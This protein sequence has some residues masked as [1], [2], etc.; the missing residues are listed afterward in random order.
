MAETDLFES[1]QALFCSVAD[2]LGAKDVGKVLNIKTYPTYKQFLEVPKHKNI[3]KKAAKQTN[4]DVSQKRIEDFLLKSDSWYKSSVQIANKVITEIHKIDK[5]FNLARK[6]YESAGFSWLRGDKEV[7]G[8]IFELYKLA[9]ESASA[10]FKWGGSKRVGMDLGFTSRNMNKWNPADIFYA[11][12]TARTAIKKELEKVR[13]L[14]G[15]KFYS[16]DNGTLNGK[17]RP[18]DG[19]NVF[20]A[21]LVDNGDL[22]PLS[23]KKQPGT[24]TLRPVN[25]DESTK[26]KL[27][28]SVEFDGATNWQPFKRLASDIRD[29]WKKIEKG[30]K[31]ETRD[32]QLKFKSDV[33]PGTIKIRHD[34]SGSGRFV[35]EAIY[36]GAKAKAG[37]IA[38][39]RDFSIIWGAVDPGPANSFIRA[40]DKGDKEFDKRK[41]EIGKDKDYL[42]KQKGGGTNQYD[43][44]MAAASAELITNATIPFIKKFFSGKSVAQKTKQNLFVRLMF[45]AITSRSPRSSRF[46]IA[47]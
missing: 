20:I 1:A 37:S 36:T 6:G 19:L 27:L 3:I 32:I 25:F 39:A 15:G 12:Q 10:N 21:R 2:L 16:F 44:Y 41:A 38:T 11:N 23:L 47:K 17:V 26:D 14:G 9:N 42:R 29:H 35:A 22:L 40:Y 4:V 8:G 33:G 34:P 13:Q 43:A 30:D 31:T 28:D 24:V 45:Q 18:D 5:D 46:V 7:M